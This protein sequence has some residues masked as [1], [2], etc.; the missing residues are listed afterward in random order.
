MTAYGIKVGDLDTAAL[1]WRMPQGTRSCP[2]PAPKRVTITGIPYRDGDIDLT[3]ATGKAAYQNRTLSYTFRRS[4]FESEA[5]ADIAASELASS[6]AQV[7]DAEVYDSLGGC[8]YVG[9]T[10]SADVEVDSS[11]HGARSVTVELT[12]RPYTKEGRL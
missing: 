8:T 4:G 10:C 12:A 1:G 5:E 11:T 2:A 3:A 9:A 7:V 6:L